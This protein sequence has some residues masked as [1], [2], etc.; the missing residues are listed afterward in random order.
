MDSAGTDGGGPSAK[1]AKLEATNPTVTLNLT[2][3]D[4]TTAAATPKLLE[5]ST[6]KSAWFYPRFE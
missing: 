2:L 6:Y 5:M 4:G 3:A 1:K